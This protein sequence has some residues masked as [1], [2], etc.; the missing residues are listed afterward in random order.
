[1]GV[2]FDLAIDI[3][4]CLTAWSVGGIYIAS[5]TEPNITQVNKVQ[6]HWL[7]SLPPLPPEFNVDWQ[8]FRNPTS[9]ALNSC[10]I[11]PGGCG[12]DFITSA[13]QAWPTWCATQL[14]VFPPWT[15]FVQGSCSWKTS[16]TTLT[17]PAKHKHRSE[18]FCRETCKTY[19]TC[20]KLMQNLHVN[21]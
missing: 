14:A 9:T 18:R 21:V 16:F 10:N 8:Y 7:F 12:G 17:T 2:V 1:M 15:A 20:V 6:F 11:E 4:C 13:M 19:G 5:K 3:W